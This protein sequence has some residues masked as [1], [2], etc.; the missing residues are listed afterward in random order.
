MAVEG[1]YVS[2][3]LQ[4]HQASYSLKHGVQGL[5]DLCAA[6]LGRHTLFLQ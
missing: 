2:S 3:L 5:V 1:K 4:N 6:R